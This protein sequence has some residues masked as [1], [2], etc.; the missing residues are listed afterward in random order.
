MDRDTDTV[1]VWVGLDPLRAQYMEQALL[2][3]GIECL[4]TPLNAAGYEAMIFEHSLWVAREDAG[5]ARRLLREL[6][7]EL[8]AQLEASA[9]D[10]IAQEE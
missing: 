9:A 2:E 10:E 7:K 6:D 4:L 1:R 5:R 3:E 8:N